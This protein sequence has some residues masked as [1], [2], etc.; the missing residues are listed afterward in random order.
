MLADSQMPEDC[1]PTLRFLIAVCQLA[2]GL[3][4]AAIRSLRSAI[5]QDE[6]GEVIGR[7][8]ALADKVVECELHGNLYFFQGPMAGAVLLTALI[9]SAA[10]RTEDIDHAYRALILYRLD[11]FAS[12]AVTP[13][14]LATAVDDVSRCC[15]DYDWEMMPLP[16]FCE[17]SVIGLAALYRLG[18]LGQALEWAASAISEVER[19]CF[20]ERDHPL[21]KP[22]DL[23]FPVLL[24][25]AGMV[26]LA[27]GHA[28]QAVD[29]LR[30]A[31]AAFAEDYDPRAETLL[32]EA[33][34]ATGDYNSA[35]VILDRLVNHPRY[36]RLSWALAPALRARADLYMRL[37]DPARA[38][39][40]RRRLAEL[41]ISSAT[42]S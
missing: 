12:N 1:R 21:E 13:E 20:Y 27:A 33:L 3:D 37:G 5:D 41:D 4:G 38:A 24:R 26:A 6:T 18:H 9:E 30:R 28:E 14:Q 34:M 17:M 40:D 2:T 32:A 10:G 7:I 8:R 29:L 23:D 39:A 19:V 11:E 42:S 31:A 22:N 16:T 25:Q 35:S 36:S 15:F